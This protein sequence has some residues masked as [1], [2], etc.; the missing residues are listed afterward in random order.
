MATET[1]GHHDAQST[2]A[3]TDTATSAME[4]DSTEHTAIA[5]QEEL[6]ANGPEG[7]APTTE[8]ATT[9]TSTIAS[10][11]APLPPQ[12]HSA[13]SSSSYTM[14]TTTN[15]TTT[16]APVAPGPR[17]ARLQDLYA[18]SLR[19]TLGK[20]A[21]DNFAACYPTVGRR[22]EGVLRQVQAQMVDKL[23]EKCEVS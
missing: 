2:T 16:A 17:A 14:A 15:T 9:S 12:Q 8:T 4:I 13:T 21:W 7:T 19:R 6:A 18:Q 22:A 10:S 11:G 20:L 1:H 23:G 3:A 5:G